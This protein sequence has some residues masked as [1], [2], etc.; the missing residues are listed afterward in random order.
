MKATG[1]ATTALSVGIS[2]IV[3]A[4]AT[5][6]AADA[7]KDTT[8]AAKE[9][10]LN[11]EYEAAAAKY[12]QS[13]KLAQGASPHVLIV[14]Y[15]NLGAAYREAH[16]FDDAQRAFK[17]AIS[18]AEKSKIETDPSAKNAML[19]Y[20]NLLKRMGHNM[21]ATLM[22]SRAL[23][24][25]MAA[26]PAITSGITPPVGNIPNPVNP[27]ADA[28]TGAMLNGHKMSLD[29]LKQFANEHPNSFQV[30]DALA[31][32]YLHLQ[33][34]PDAIKQLQLINQRFPNQEKRLHQFLAVCYS[35]SGDS[36]NAVSEIQ[37]DLSA[38]PAN[39]R[40]D[41][42]LLHGYYMEQGDIKAAS[43]VDRQFLE[44]FPTDPQ[45]PAVTS[46]LDSLSKVNTNGGRSRQYDV[47]KNYSWPLNYFPL[48][49]FILP[50]DDS[51]RL[52][53]SALGR[54]EDRPE[55]IVTTALN[56]WAGASLNKVSFTTAL[57][58]KE[59][60]IEISFVTN[61][62]GLEQGVAGLTTFGSREE[63]AKARLQILIVDDSGKP[64]TPE[65]LLCVTLHELGHALFLEHSTQPGDIMF[66]QM[67]G[68]P[69]C[70]LSSNDAQ[71][72]TKLY[73]SQ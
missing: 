15:S 58:A 2:L 41:Y 20:A 64:A 50:I 29:E 70:E 63:H 34:W 49:V 60:N 1:W 48:K 62:N 28:A 4:A 21:E 25:A 52:S 24:K 17:S 73:S 32:E 43:D 14:L 11:H 55:Q 72:V 27:T 46:I 54:M 67:R 8:R 71:R 69:Q 42:L 35:K 37:Y 12:E 31:N 33:K 56:Q 6:A 57:T 44:K 30:N 36:A 7:L 5:D 23:G 3:A 66:P 47:G 53:R 68:A 38:N 16:K 40:D 65:K 18:H 61:P 26:A 13:I 45:A 39:A 22:E 51:Y 59:S 19:Q 9:A 10:Y